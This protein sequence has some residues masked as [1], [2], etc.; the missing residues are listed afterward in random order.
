MRE[1]LL[2]KK[3]KGRKQ[4]M[5][6]EEFMNGVMKASMKITPERE[7][8][9]EH[10]L[11]ESIDSMTYKYN[12]VDYGHHQLI[13]AME[14]LSELQKEVSKKLRGKGNQAAILEEIADVYIIL[15]Y[16][17]IICGFDQEDVNRAINVKMDR[18][19]ALLDK[20]DGQVN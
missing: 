9:I 10:T 11:E 17:R 4:R 7:K 12:G 18:L 13:I 2:C 20:K 16:I 15:K 14:E 8:E 5:D 3:G 19:R 1:V 6:S